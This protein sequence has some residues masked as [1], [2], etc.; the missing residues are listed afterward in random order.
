MTNIPVGPDPTHL[1]HKS[2]TSQE[3]D[4]HLYPCRDSE[5]EAPED[6]CSVHVMAEEGR[7]FRRWNC[8]RGGKEGAPARGL[9]KEQK[10][11]RLAGLDQDFLE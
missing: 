3:V 6:K 8:L 9:S 5:T 1:G 11:P 4:G 10:E 7:G 2:L